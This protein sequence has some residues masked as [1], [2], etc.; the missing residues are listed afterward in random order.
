MVFNSVTDLSD[1][2][3]LA[4]AIRE[5]FHLKVCPVKSSTLPE[6]HQRV[7]VRVLL[8]MDQVLDLEG[9]VIRLLGNRG[10]LLK[11]RR[12]LDMSNLRSLAGL[13]AIPTGLDLSI[14]GADD[15]YEAPRER[16]GPPPSRPVDHAGVE[17][18]PPGESWELSPLTGPV[19]G[20]LV[21]RVIDNRY[22]V[23]NILGQGGMGVVYEAMHKYLN[24][25]VAIKVLQRALASDEAYVA[26]FLREAQA[27]AAL[28]N[29]HTITVHDFGVTEDGQ[30]YF[31]MELLEGLPLT[32]VIETESPIPFERAVDLLTQ[33]C[34]SL[35]E[36]HE[37]GILH[38]DL[39][40]DNLFI[41]RNDGEE[42]L[43]VL[44]FGIAKKVSQATPTVRITDTGMIPGTPHYVSPEQAH[45]REATPCSDLYALGII[46]YEML[47]G[48]PPFDADSGVGVLLKHI[49]ELPT[50]LTVAYPFLDIHPSVDDL[51]AVLL[52]KDPQRRPQTARQFST[53][54]IQYRDRI[55][56]EEE[57]L[58]DA[59]ASRGS[60]SM[61]EETGVPTAPTALKRAPMLDSEST[62]PG[63]VRAVSREN[64]PLRDTDLDSLDSITLEELEEETTPWLDDAGVDGRGIPWRWIAVGVAAAAAAAG[65]LF[66]RP[67]ELLGL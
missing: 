6:I 14:G 16:P 25:K 33:T 54:L 39:K 26:R 23:T 9:R 34:D 13:P 3:N 61:T 32:D 12:K 46:L 35:A 29:P 40:P 42:F 5:Y 52:D 19:V 24:R 48:H 8:P 56:R 59:P 31:A 51:L 49:Q 63:T 64:P 66:W 27:V 17:E 41:T 2:R 10:F 65:L 28:K 50:P 45:G 7:K 15:S 57:D 62:A 1:P 36:A 4:K 30:L 38:R 44:D 60:S 20:Q 55:R 21:G 47:C 22:Q 37:A 67:W 18:P 11:F 53:L 58:L 43:T